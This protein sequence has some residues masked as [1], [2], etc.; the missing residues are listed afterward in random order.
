MKLLFIPAFLLLPLA[1]SAADA[2]DTRSMVGVLM[3]A[4]C[5]TNAGGSLHIETPQVL[6][7]ARETKQRKTALREGTRG[8][9]IVSKASAESDPY[10]SCKAT[11]ATTDFAIHTDG[12]LL[13]LDEEGNELVRQQMRNDSF[14]ASLADESG[15]PR[16][17]TVMVEGRKTG[18]RLTITSLRR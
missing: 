14:R 4:N 3:D 6:A 16:W 7:A 13:L 8:R 12:Q 17:L 18:D 9:S 15:A 1:A 11:A 5:A 10:D 2:P